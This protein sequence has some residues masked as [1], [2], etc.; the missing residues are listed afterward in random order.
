MGGDT[1]GIILVA[2]D[3]DHDRLARLDLPLHPIRGLLD[4]ALLEARLDGRDGAAH[5]V[6]AVEVDRGLG[7]QSSVSDST[8]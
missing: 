1:A 6:D 8:K 5:L 7:L 2:V 4:V 3:A